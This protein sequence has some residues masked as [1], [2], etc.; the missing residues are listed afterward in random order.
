M[1]ASIV[2]YIVWMIAPLAIL[3]LAEHW[4]SLPVQEVYDPR[5]GVPVYRTRSETLARILARRH[6]MDYCPEG[7]GWS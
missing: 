5:D 3:F 6:R 7:E 2:A 1:N 4:L